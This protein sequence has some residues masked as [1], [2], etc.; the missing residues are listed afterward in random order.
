MTSSPP[1]RLGFRSSSGKVLQDSILLLLFTQLIGIERD[2]LKHA[3]PCI[4][5]LG[6]VCFFNSMQSLIDTLTITRLIAMLK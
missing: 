2:I 4:F 5:Q 1:I 3:F 6:A